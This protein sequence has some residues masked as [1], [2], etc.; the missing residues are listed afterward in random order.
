MWEGGG[1]RRSRS[2]QQQGYVSLPV[3]PSRVASLKAS[4]RLC[5]HVPSSAHLSCRTTPLSIPPASPPCVRA[6]AGVSVVTGVRKWGVGVCA[7][8]WREGSGKGPRRGS[9]LT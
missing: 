3:S 5:G 6:G 4:T 1:R 8:R 9:N 7:R 2:F